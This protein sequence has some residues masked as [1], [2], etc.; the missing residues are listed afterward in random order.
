LQ[1]QSEENGGEDL[2]AAV[3]TRVEEDP[4][5]VTLRSELRTLL[6]QAIDEL[7]DKERKVL[8]LYYLEEMTMKEV[9]AILDIGESR[10]SQIHTA[11]LIRLR[12]RLATSGKSAKDA[13]KEKKLL[14]QHTVAAELSTKPQ[15]E[16]AHAA[17]SKSDVVRR[18]SG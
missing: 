10:V 16:L 14:P 7:D 15:R 2:S 8:A 13:D 1:A 12:A 6:T 17:R 9:G 3:A 18:S 11:A 5:T 4:F